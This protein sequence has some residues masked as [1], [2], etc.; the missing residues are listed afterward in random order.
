MFSAVWS[1][2]R[3]RHPPY[4]PQWLQSRPAREVWLSNSCY[5]QTQTVY[6]FVHVLTLLRSL[7]PKSDWGCLWT[8]SLLALWQTLSTRSGYANLSLVCLKQFVLHKKEVP[9]SSSPKLMNM[10]GSLWSPNL[11]AVYKKP[12]IWI[13][14]SDLDLDSVIKSCLRQEQ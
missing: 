4:I 12:S 10:E 3:E 7:M 2:T 1:Q 5:W 13:N 8:W 6:K 14:L 9:S 11:V